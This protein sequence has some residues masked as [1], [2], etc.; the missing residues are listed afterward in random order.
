[1]IALRGGAVEHNRLQIAWLL[2]AVC[3]QTRSIFHH[4]PAFVSSPQNQL[5]R[6]PTSG[7]AAASARASAKSSKA[8]A[9]WPTPAAPTSAA[10]AAI[11]SAPPPRNGSIHKHPFIPP[12]TRRPEVLR[13]RNSNLSTKKKITRI[14]NGRSANRILRCAETART[15]GRAESVMP[16]SV[17]SWRSCGG[18]STAEP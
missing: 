10:S 15:G 1:M 11:S 16:R 18:I 5:T 13:L 8:A 14:A 2:P 4:V 6:L 9:T 17:M 7:S 12:P 3:G